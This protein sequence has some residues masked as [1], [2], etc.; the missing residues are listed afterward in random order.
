MDTLIKLLF[1]TNLLNTFNAFYSNGQPIIVQFFVIDSMHS[2]KD[3]R[4]K[5]AKRVREEG[6][7]EIGR[8]K[9]KKSS[10]V[11]YSPCIAVYRYSLNVNYSVSLVRFSLATSILNLS[12]LR[13]LF[14]VHRLY[15]INNNM[16][17]FPLQL[18]LELNDIGLNGYFNFLYLIIHPNH[19]SIG[20]FSTEVCKEL[21]TEF[22]KRAVIKPPSHDMDI[23]EYLDFI[24]VSSR[25]GIPVVENDFDELVN[26]NWIKWKKGY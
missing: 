2:L 12:A 14:N 8:S 15:E 22:L 20:T 7:Y 1:T 23:L 26:T 11:V 3:A 24:G 9:V 19:Y 21:D 17:N 13:M 10:H 25:H 6:Y 18:S 16:V 5:V 4:E